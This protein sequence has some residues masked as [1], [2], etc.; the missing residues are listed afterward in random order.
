MYKRHV[1]VTVRLFQSVTR[2]PRFCQ[3]YLRSGTTRLLRGRA[4]SQ[5]AFLSDHSVACQI[6]FQGA[7]DYTEAFGWYGPVD[8]VHAARSCMSG[9]SRSARLVPTA[10]KS[11]KDGFCFLE[12]LLQ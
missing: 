9:T 4:S 11:V 12:G 1:L 6:R 7:F 5:E 10:Y 3:N 8:A 2:W